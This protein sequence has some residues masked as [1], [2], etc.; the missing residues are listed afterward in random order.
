MTKKH[1]YCSSEEMRRRVCTVCGKKIDLDIYFE[2]IYM[3][4]EECPKEVSRLGRMVAYAYIYLT[5]LLWEPIKHG[6]SGRR[7]QRRS[8]PDYSGHFKSG[9]FLPTD[10]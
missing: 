2:M 5:Y 9:P 8:G 1:S 10:L 6:L 4:G 7:R 3:N